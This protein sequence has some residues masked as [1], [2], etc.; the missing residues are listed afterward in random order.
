MSGLSDNLRV[1]HLLEE[2]SSESNITE[3]GIAVLV[4]HI[5]HVIR[6]IRITFEIFGDNNLFCFFS[7]R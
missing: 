7:F 4:E 1:Q 3:K 5:E 2:L 6:K